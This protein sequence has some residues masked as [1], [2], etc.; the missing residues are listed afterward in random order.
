MKL[1]LKMSGFVLFLKINVDWKEYKMA[2]FFIENCQINGKNVY[3][4]KENAKHLINVLRCKIGDEIEVSTGDG[5]DYLCRIDEI[6]DLKVIA[7]II[8]CFGNETEPNTKITLF[9]AI[10]KGDKMDFIIQKCV[11]L[12]IDEI[13][14]I[15]TDRT[16]V[17]L[18]GKEEKKLIR[19]N[20][21]SEAAAKQSKR[22][23]IP[24]VS[25]IL[26]FK[27]AILKAENFELCLIPYEKEKKNNIKNI[28]NEFKG[29][30]I[31]VFI[32]PEGGF[33]ENEIKLAIESNIFSV[34][35]GKRILRTE[36]AGMVTTAILIYELE[37]LN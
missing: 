12:G 32:G 28:L 6:E 19:W 24:L 7:I 16:I 11:E 9:Q 27:Q 29:N 4:E 36:T 26:D 37:G 22:G 18:K 1:L 35:L 23:K 20:K 2:K 10:S 13:V 8:D 17:D 25:E 3:I 31:G 14:P 30:N 21:I 34:T 5:F 33:T 15:K